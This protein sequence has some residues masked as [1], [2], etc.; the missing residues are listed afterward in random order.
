MT[1]KHLNF[2]NI[3]MKWGFIYFKLKNVFTVLKSFG[4]IDIIL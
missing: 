2:K 3:D 1:S 4:N